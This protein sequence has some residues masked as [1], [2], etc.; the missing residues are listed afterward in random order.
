MQ[1]KLFDKVPKPTETIDRIVKKQDCGGCQLLPEEEKK[2]IDAAKKMKHLGPLDFSDDEDALSLDTVVSHKS[3]GSDK[4]N[5]SHKSAVKPDEMTSFHEDAFIAAGGMDVASP[6][7]DAAEG[8]SWAIAASGKC[9]TVCG[10]F[11]P[12][13]PNTAKD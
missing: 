6:V 7:G 3:K 13:G 11:A 10:N 4:S 1:S 2:K 5:D 12:K 8:E 9:K